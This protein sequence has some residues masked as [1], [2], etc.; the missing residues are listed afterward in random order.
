MR[1]ALIRFAGRRLVLVVA[2]ACGSSSAANNNSNG[3][4][5][6]G[7]PA[8]DPAATNLAALSTPLA[9]NISIAS[10]AGYQVMKVALGDNGQ[11]GNRAIAGTT[12][13]LSLSLVA[14]RDALVRV[15]VNPGASFKPAP[16]TARVKVQLSGPTGT[17]TQIFFA[18]KTV[19]TGSVEADLDSTINVKVPGSALEPGAMFGVVLNQVGGDTSPAATST[20]RYPQ[21]GTLADMAVG[22]GGDVIH[23]KVVPFKYDADGSGRLPAIDEAQL[24]ILRDRFYQLY[25]TAT[26]DMTVR[27]AIPWS[28]AISGGG[29]GFGEALKTMGDLHGKDGAPNDLY[30]YGMFEPTADFGQFCGGGCITGLS[31]LGS[32]TSVGIGYPGEGTAG[33]MVHEVGHAHGLD[34]APFCNATSQM[35]YW[36][37]DASHDG[38]HLGGWGYDSI[39]NKMIDPSSTTDFMSYCGNNW[40]SDFHYARLFQRI[41]GDNKFY[42]D[43]V[44]DFRGVQ[45]P[46]DGQ[47]SWEELPTNQAW[48]RNGEPR[49]VEVVQIDG[50]T[51][52]KTAYYFP[53]DHL[54]GGKLMVP[55]D[56]IT[57]AAGLRFASRAIALP[58]H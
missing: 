55:N 58:T 49:D 46:S 16:I 17:R 31:N 7:F 3:V 11:P 28:T 20:A 9:Q 34:H 42:A 48:I 37:K 25:P 6:S 44:G 18:Q 43:M 5:G 47:A 51:A 8:D 38:A 21:D 23:I 24:K 29:Q 14:N 56:A 41:K 35:N 39:G 57:G 36:P 13:P 22:G 1:R 53:F 12:P 33:T 19:T 4:D 30:Y 15:F 40:V 52:I 27:D 10:V 45:L 54:P 2:L 50:T 26:V 32:P